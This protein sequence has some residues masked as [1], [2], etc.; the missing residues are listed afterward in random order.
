MY[1][2]KIFNSGILFYVKALSFTMLLVF[3]IEF[4]WQD[5]YKLA[6]EISRIIILHHGNLKMNI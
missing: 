6:N 4:L 3:S 1:I 5:N 2:K